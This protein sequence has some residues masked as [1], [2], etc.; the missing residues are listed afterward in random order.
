MTLETCNLFKFLWNGY[1]RNKVQSEPVGNFLVEEH[2]DNSVTKIYV[3]GKP[4]LCLT[5]LEEKRLLLK[6]TYRNSPCSP[7]KPP[8]GTLECMGKAFGERTVLWSSKFAVSW[9]DVN[10][11]TLN[12]LT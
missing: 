7:H 11:P 6:I 2:T 10:P 4:S 12:L 5:L 8:V 9:Q 1:D 3:W